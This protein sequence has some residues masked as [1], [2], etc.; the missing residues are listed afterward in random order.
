MSAEKKTGDTGEPDDN[1]KLQ[2][3]IAKGVTDI[4]ANESVTGVENSGRVSWFGFG[5]ILLAIAYFVTSDAID[6]QAEILITIALV[7]LYQCIVITVSALSRIAQKAASILGVLTMFTVTYE[8][9]GLNVMRAFFDGISKAAQQSQD[10]DE[11]AET[12]VENS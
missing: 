1:Y 7:Y 9:S 12:E 2:E 4:I 11:Q 5:L 6:T 8:E 3:K 10:S